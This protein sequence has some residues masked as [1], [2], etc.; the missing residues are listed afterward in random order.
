MTLGSQVEWALHC[1]T[2]L[3]SLP[4]GSTV[5]AARLAEFHGVPKEY[6]AKALQQLA[7][8]GLVETST[9]P[10]GGYSLAHPPEKV[11]LLDVI[12][13]VEGK[14]RS[15]DCTEIRRNNPCWPGARRLTLPP[16]QIAAVMYEADGAWRDVLRKKTLA[17]IVA[18]VRVV[19][20][21]ALMDA[22]RDWLLK[23]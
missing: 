19:A 21:P 15:F 4:P 13:A 7:A 10:R 9:G 2:A 22:T 6:L 8:A 23:G 20:P 5:T 17:H 14:Q 12:E 1:M 3:G 18:G 16:C 11:S